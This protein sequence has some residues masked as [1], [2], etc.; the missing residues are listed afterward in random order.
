VSDYGLINLPFLPT[1]LAPFFDAGLAWSKGDSPTIEFTQGN[2]A[3]TT[4]ARVPVFSTGVAARVNLLGYVVLE[5]YYAHAFQRPDKP[6]VWG[7]QILP[8]W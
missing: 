3:R 4:T 7:F 2:A 5:F 1:E 6:N 8:G